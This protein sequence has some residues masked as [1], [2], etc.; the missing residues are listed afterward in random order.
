MNEM[1]ALQRFGL[2]EKESAVYSTMLKLGGSSAEKIA[3]SAGLH[4]RTVYDCLAS[5]QK[6][7]LVAA[8]VFEKGKKYSALGADAFLA[9]VDE[10]K[11]MAEELLK[12]AEKKQRSISEMPS[13]KIFVGENGM[14]SVLADI[15]AVGKTW[16]VYGGSGQ[17]AQLKYYSPKFHKQRFEKNIELF[18]IYYDK[19]EI[20][21]I[22]GKLQLS[23]AK[24]ISEKLATPVIFWLYGNKLVLVF[25]KETKMLIQIENEEFAKSFRNFFNIA[26]KSMK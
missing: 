17:A 16:F 22:I 10:G 3:V 2:S 24:Y 26:W 5:L 7:G 20:R 19:P 8:E 23:K 13:V 21:S 15:L 14:K 4:K 25:W 6:K 12:Q 1:S 18:G 9:W 11:A